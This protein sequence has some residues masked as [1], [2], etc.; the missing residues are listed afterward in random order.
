MWYENII[1][2]EQAI[3]HFQRVF[4]NNRLNHAYIFQGG[5]GVGKKEFSIYL[6]QAILCDQGFGLGCGKC[7]S[8]LRVKNQTHPDFIL[9]EPLEQ[10][11]T[12]S[13]E[14]IRSLISRLSRR[15]H[16]G[17]KRLVIINPFDAVTDQGVNAFLKTLEEPPED[18]VFILISSNP[19]AIRATI[20]SRCQLIHFRALTKKEMKAFLL[21][22]TADLNLLNS[23]IALAAGNKEQALSF[24]RDQEMRKNISAIIDWFF[25]EENWNLEDRGNWID[26][27]EKDNWNWEDYQVFWQIWSSM[28]RD[29]LLIELGS[30][31][32]QLNYPDLRGRYEAMKAKSILQ[33]NRRIQEIQKAIGLLSVRPPRNPIVFAE[34][35]LMNWNGES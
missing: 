19:V 29:R 6:S 2:Q 22:E 10:R 15:I 23:A 20:L 33:L 16:Q 27:R 30:Q 9:L 28:Y 34:A 12:I 26:T 31:S 24:L 25:Q 18:T 14:Q 7:S 4:K 8:C 1:G 5:E 3:E 11:K 21:E 13:I 35:I 32:D 17:R